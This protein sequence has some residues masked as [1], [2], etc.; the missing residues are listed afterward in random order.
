MAYEVEDF[1][2][3]M[4]G[5]FH[6]EYSREGNQRRGFKNYNATCLGSRKAYSWQSNFR[7]LER[8]KWFCV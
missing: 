6:L 1:D 5:H 2:D 8:P 4:T 3:L 7:L